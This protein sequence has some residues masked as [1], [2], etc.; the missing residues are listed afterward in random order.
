MQEKI[1]HGEY[2]DF[3]KLL[4]KD[5]I[6]VEEDSRMELVVKN[7]QTYWTPMSEVVVI[8]CFSRWEQAFRIF[9]NIYTIQYP[10]R[11]S[12]LIQYYHIIHSIASMYVW[13]NVYA[14]DH[15]FRLHISRHPERSW[16]VIL[17]QAWSMKLHD[18]I[19]QHYQPSGMTVVPQFNNNSSGN[20]GTP[21]TSKGGMP[22][23]DLIRAGANLVQTASMI[24]SVPTVTNL[25]I[26]F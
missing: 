7:G 3:S 24:I 8:N 22:A 11:S 6:T 16:S 23:T 18:K 13:D 2:V 17:Q 10:H 12:K 21:C 5:H 4:P 20:A 15:E 19:T 9:S 25:V 1:R 26:Q 14:Y